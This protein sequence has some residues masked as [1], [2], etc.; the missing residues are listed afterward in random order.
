MVLIGHLV[1]WRYAE[2]FSTLAVQIGAFLS[3]LG[4]E[5]FFVISGFVITHLSLAEYRIGTFSIKHFYLRRAI[6]IIPPLL[7]YL[8][9]ITVLTNAGLIHQDLNGIIKAAA[10]SC[11][12]FDDCDW[13]VGHTWTLAYEWQFYLAF[14]MLLA[15]GR[16]LP[17]FLYAISIAI[18]VAIF[19]GCFPDD[20]KSIVFLAAGSLIASSSGTLVPLMNWR[21]WT[22]AMKWTRAWFLQALGA[23]SYSLYLWQQLFTGS[24]GRYSATSFFEPWIAI[25]LAY[26]SYRLL[27]QGVGRFLKSKLRHSRQNHTP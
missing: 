9:T 15:L 13:F 1:S 10:F 2:Y 3:N 17:A 24:P 6:R 20:A 21:V 12:V 18:I 27:E 8:M 14:P 22:Y 19:L 7:C 5:L 16:F 4:V 25:A 23:I 26:A 11:N